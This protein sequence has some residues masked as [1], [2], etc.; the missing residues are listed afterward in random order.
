M[1]KHDVVELWG[2]DH[3]IFNYSKMWIFPEKKEK[4]EASRRV[5]K[6]GQQK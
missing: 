2:K 1:K 3:V 5:R 6:K 4:P